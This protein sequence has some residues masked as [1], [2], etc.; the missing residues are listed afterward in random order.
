M[1]E[2]GRSPADAGSGCQPPAS[3]AEEASSQSGIPNAATDELTILSQAH[4]ELRS[5][6]KH[7]MAALQA[8]GNTEEG[9]TEATGRSRREA[10]PLSQP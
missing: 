6:V 10:G 2:I 3:A 9:V 1:T 5:C 8:F 4:E 7:A